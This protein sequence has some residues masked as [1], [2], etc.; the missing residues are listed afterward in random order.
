MKKTLLV[1]AQL[2]SVLM[3]L[4]YAACA[5]SRLVRTTITS[6][7]C[8]EECV[9]DQK[10]AICDAVIQTALCELR[11]LDRS[12]RKQS[13]SSVGSNGEYGLRKEGK[14]PPC[15]FVKKKKKKKKKKKNKKKKKKRRR[16]RRRTK[17]KTRRRAGRE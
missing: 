1:E 15:W 11:K 13:S 6:A 8:Y 4:S 10:K 3:S 2:L 17:K 16:R 14:Q 12:M 9:F 5:S 7:A